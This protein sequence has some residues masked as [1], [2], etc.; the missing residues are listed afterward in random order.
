MQLVVISTL[1]TRILRSP[2]IEYHFK[3]KYGESGWLPWSDQKPICP[4]NPTFVRLIL[5]LTVLM[6]VWISLQIELMGWK[7][8]R[9]RKL[10]TP[11]VNLNL[12]ERMYKVA[13]LIELCRWM[14]I[15]PSF[16]VLDTTHP[17]PT[18]PL[19]APKTAFLEQS[20]NRSL[21][22]WQSQPSLLDLATPTKS[23]LKIYI[24]ERGS[25]ITC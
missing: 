22:Y 4:R 15:V 6:K 11:L 23:L 21:V 16:A 9:R 10:K 14:N 18:P 13:L 8:E 7:T 3:G 20:R 2:F 12:E 5:S 24:K 1:R 17:A 19:I 25:C